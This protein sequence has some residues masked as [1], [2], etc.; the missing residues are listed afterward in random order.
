MPGAPNTSDRYGRALYRAGI[1]A[2]LVYGAY[3]V[4]DMQRR[5]ATQWMNIYRVDEFESWSET[6]A[7]PHRLQVKDGHSALEGA[8]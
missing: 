5:P 8:E 6:F 2:L 7:Y 3:A 1:V 4:R